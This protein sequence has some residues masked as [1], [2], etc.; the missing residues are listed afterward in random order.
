M[1]TITHDKFR[2]RH[3]DRHAS[4]VQE[5]VNINS[6]CSG[7]SIRGDRQKFLR[8]KQ[9]IKKISNSRLR[10]ALETDGAEVV[11]R[12]IFDIFTNDLIGFSSRLFIKNKVGKLVSAKSILNAAQ[13][14]D[15][16]KHV[17]PW[18]ITRALQKAS[19]ACDNIRISLPIEENL[20]KNN[21]L[22]N[23]LDMLSDDLLSE[24]KKR[25]EFEFKISMIET[26][27][28]Y[29]H[30]LRNLKKGNYKVSLTNCEENKFP[31]W[32]FSEVHPDTVTLGYSFIKGGNVDYE[33]RDGADLGEMLVRSLLETLPD[34]RVR[35]EYI[36][37]QEHSL[38]YM[39][40]IG[41][42]EYCTI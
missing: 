33:M 28:T 21:A 14:I 15:T 32:L 26:N 24:V 30:G 22:L 42:M 40:S 23:V 16:V 13:D 1:D 31:L 39:R 12:D 34:V 9:R 11:S 8:N 20:L 19:E 36:P 38:A 6:D 29:I 17:M 37:N 5:F 35:S 2:N 3:K 10:Y 25:C 18:I 7:S 41:C 27:D 4:E